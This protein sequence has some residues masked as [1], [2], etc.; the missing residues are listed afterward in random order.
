MPGNPGG[1]S[2]GPSARGPGV[3]VGRVALDWAAGGVGVGGPGGAASAQVRRSSPPAWASEDQAGLASVS[4]AEPGR[5]FRRGRRFVVRSRRSRSLFACRTGGVFG[6]G[7]LHHRC[8][9]RR[10]G[11]G[12][13]IRKPDSRWNAAAIRPPKVGGEPHRP[14]RDRYHRHRRCRGERRRE[15]EPVH[16]RPDIPEHRPQGLG[17]LRPEAG[18][19]RSPEIRRGRNVGWAGCEM[20]LQQTFHLPVVH[21]VVSVHRCSPATPCSS[22]NR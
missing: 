21:V 7:G 13:H 4:H 22:L 14:A 1:A 2:P 3:G 5:R 16:R 11:V 20:L 12:A 19:Q 15:A 10:R 8:H 17:V 9:R 6:F 18:L